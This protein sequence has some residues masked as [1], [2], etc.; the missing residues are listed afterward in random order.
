MSLY[1]NIHGFD[2]DVVLH[3]VHILRQGAIP[4]QHHMHAASQH[5]QLYQYVR[6]LTSEWLDDLC[7]VRV[8]QR[9]ALVKRWRHQAL[10]AM[11]FDLHKKTEFRRKLIS[12]KNA[13]QHSYTI[14]KCAWVYCA[15]TCS[16]CNISRGINR[17][18]CQA[19]LQYFA[20][21]EAV[22]RPVR[23]SSMVTTPVE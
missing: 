13:L 21:H 15:C 18:D 12:W 16:W 4:T 9:H 19:Y 11:C 8:P 6:K 17:S 5:T 2:V 7:I 20:F 10:V 22:M 23:M 3:Y 14:R 1:K